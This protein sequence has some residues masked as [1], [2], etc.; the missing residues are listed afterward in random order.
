M[1][2]S[3]SSSSWYDASSHSGSVSLEGEEIL[4]YYIPQSWRQWIFGDKDD[5]VPQYQA[6]PI[7]LQFQPLYVNSDISLSF[8]SSES[9]C[10]SS[11]SDSSHNPLPIPANNRRYQMAKGIGKKVKSPKVKDTLNCDAQRN[12]LRQN[13]L[14]NSRFAWKQSTASNDYARSRGQ[15]MRRWTWKDMQRYCPTLH[16]T[17]DW[18]IKTFSTTL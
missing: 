5:M 10:G 17:N 1:F 9:S 6:D 3:A 12:S 8:T 15:R 16:F 13:R 11:S 18:L 2:G 4:S 7:L 14:L